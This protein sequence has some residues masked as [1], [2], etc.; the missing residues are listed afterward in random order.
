[1]VVHADMNTPH[2]VT[3]WQRV[4]AMLTRHESGAVITPDRTPPKGKRPFHPWCRYSD[5]KAHGVLPIGFGTKLPR[6]YKLKVIALTLPL[7]MAAEGWR[8][9]HIRRSLIY[10][11]RSFILH[12]DIFWSYDK[13]A[14]YD[15]ESNDDLREHC[16]ATSDVDPD[17]LVGL[18]NMTHR[19][20]GGGAANYFSLRPI[21]SHLPGEKIWWLQDW[22]PGNRLFRW[23]RVAAV[24]EGGMLRSTRTDELHGERKLNRQW[25][26]KDLP[27][28]SLH[29]D[30][31][32]IN[33][34]P[35]YIPGQPV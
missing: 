15:W 31:L 3:F 20:M 18:L 8:R 34:P 2:G 30:G 25:E 1:M 13:V 10:N 26:N 19:P 14:P 29:D 9:Q 32:V 22:L 24:D 17:T 7:L 23:W 35:H 11:P 27:R 28:N 12:P 4:E 33:A 21:A 6:Y 5:F 16:K